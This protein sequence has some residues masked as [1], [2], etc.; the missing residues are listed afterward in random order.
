M[1]HDYRF[2][3]ARSAASKGEGKLGGLDSNQRMA[4]SKSAAFSPKALRASG[5]VSLRFRF[6]ASRLRCGKAANFDSAEGNAGGA[7]FEPTHGGVTVR[8]LFSQ[9]APRFGSRFF[10]IPLRRFA[11]ALR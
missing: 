5:P 3:P 11:P 1:D 7:G 8:C 6:G 4:E 10:E 2:A 9:S